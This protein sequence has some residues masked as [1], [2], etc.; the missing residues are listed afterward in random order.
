[1][2]HQEKLE[3][4]RNLS[5]DEFRKKVLIPLF[6]AMGYQNVIE[7]HGRNERGK[8]II[9]HETDYVGEKI[10]TAV[11][12]K[13]ERIH[14]TEEASVYS[15]LQGQD[16]LRGNPRA[17]YDRGVGQEAQVASN[18]DQSLEE[19]VVGRCGIGIRRWRGG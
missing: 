3:K 13:K 1:M 6:I 8:D 2:D 15:Q 11:V 9:F 12:V 16:S 7:Y 14:G 5:E 17:P 19:A 10:Y 4:I 18:A